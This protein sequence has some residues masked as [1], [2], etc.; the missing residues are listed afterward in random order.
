MKLAFQKKQAKSEC[1]INNDWLAILHPQ[2]IRMWCG[3]KYRSSN[4]RQG[5]SSKSPRELPLGS[6][7]GR[8][9]EEWHR[10]LLDILYTFYSY[11]FKM[12]HTYYLDVNTSYFKKTIGMPLFNLS[13][14]QRFKKIKI[15]WYEKRHTP[16]PLSL[17]VRW[18]IRK[19]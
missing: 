17:S 9:G 13:N 12:T 15:C 8:G 16:A 18:S 10:R 3:N 6:R 19:Y 11:A 1:S 14:W 5:N 2:Y 7:T 4:T